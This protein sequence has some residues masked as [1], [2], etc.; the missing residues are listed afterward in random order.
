MSIILNRTTTVFG[1]VYMNNENENWDILEN[2]SN[3]VQEQLNQIVIEGSIDPE[4]KQARVDA[5][6]V[7]YNTVKERIDAE[8]TKTEVN[9]AEISSVLVKNFERFLDYQ[10]I[11]YSIDTLLTGASDFP[12]GFSIN[13]EANELYIARQ[14]NG[15]TDV[16]IS[17]YSLPSCTLL[18][19]KAFPKS[20]GAYQEGL[21]FFYDANKKL[22]F[23]VRVDYSDNLAIFNYTDGILG[24]NIACL[25]GSKVACDKDKKYLITSYGTSDR[26]ERIFIY[27]FK[28]I[29][30]KAP[31]LIKT[32]YLPNAVV[33]GEKIQGLTII[34]DKIVLGQGKTYPS[35]TVIDFSGT[36]LNTT[37]L[38]KKDL[39][40]LAKKF[41][42]QTIDVN[43]FIYENEGVTFY[44]YNGKLLPVICHIIGNKMYLTL[45]GSIELEKINTALNTSKTVSNSIK[46][47]DAT[48]EPTVTNYASD[49][50]VRYGKDCNGIVYIEGVCTHP[51]TSQNPNLVLLKLPFPYAPKRNKFFNTQASGGADKRNRIEIKKNGDVILVTTTST[52]TSPFTV[53][54]SI[55]FNAE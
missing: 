3:S 42:N 22:C 16:K 25:G 21:P 32:I 45:C 33:D 12:Q 6:G 11:L 20:T 48:L 41:D 17:R 26:I 35:I 8:Q 19:T 40:T 38:N 54:D 18:D 29:L 47:V 55:I 52:A 49:V 50:T 53:L 2:T 34:D 13:Q 30:D 36:I 10:K 15:G 24:E 1:R 39:G 44:Q 27:D 37:E 43:D 31:V 4:T 51:Y 9:A 14:I 5:N 46:W 28:S 7:T 23:L